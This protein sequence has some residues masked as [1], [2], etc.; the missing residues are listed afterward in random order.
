MF[1]NLKTSVSGRLGLFLVLFTILL[2]GISVGHASDQLFKNENGAA[3]SN[4]PTGGNP[5]FT[6]T[7]LY[8]IDRIL[9]YHWNTGQ[10]KSPG[11]IWLVNAAGQNYGPWTAAVQSK[12]Y[13][14]VE[15]KVV[16]PANTYT[17]HDSDPATWSHNGR[18]KNQGFAQV[19]G[20]VT[21]LN[22][23]PTFEAVKGR[24]DRVFPHDRAAVINTLEEPKKGPV[25]A[26]FG[27]RPKPTLSLSR[28][29]VSLS[30]REDAVLQVI[31]PV[32]GVPGYHI[33]C[34]DPKVKTD[35]WGMD[36]TATF[37]F[38][39]YNLTNAKLLGIEMNKPY[40]F[41]IHQNL[42]GN[43]RDSTGPSTEIGRVT[44]TYMP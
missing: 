27:L 12:F 8:T 43:W 19:Y 28:N 18:S 38:S 10:G 15:P 39:V 31:N 1:A 6:T 33:S 23:L 20:T 37:R 40:T 5:Q 22:V 29:V 34:T 2:G 36:Q 25:Q 26:H 44:I 30:K 32:P 3:V 24:V 4:N 17:I 14:V 35:G 9:T 7:K 41:V 11:Q 21:D 16:V 13:W 42:V